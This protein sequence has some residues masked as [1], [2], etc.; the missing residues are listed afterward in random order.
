MGLGEV[1]GGV[2]VGAGRGVRLG[3]RGGLAVGLCV[4]LGDSLGLGLGVDLD[5]GLGVGC[6]AGRCVG[7]GV[8]KGEGS[9]DGRGRGVSGRGEGGYIGVNPAQSSGNGGMQR[10]SS[11]CTGSSCGSSGLL[12]FTSIRG[13]TF[14]LATG[15]NMLAANT[16]FGSTVGRTSPT[17]RVLASTS[18]SR[19]GGDWSRAALPGWKLHRMHLVPW[20]ASGL[21][22]AGGIKEERAGGCCF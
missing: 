5:F 12:T 4:G 19:S 7:L 8:R 17:R 11:L 15:A 1:V 13:C 16:F 2:G 9:I 20:S 10:L 22:A 14:L 3:F 18:Y 6:G 21:E